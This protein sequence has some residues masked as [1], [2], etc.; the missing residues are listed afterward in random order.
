M[1][2]VFNREP[3]KHFVRNAIMDTKR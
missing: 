1:I 3:Q 2:F